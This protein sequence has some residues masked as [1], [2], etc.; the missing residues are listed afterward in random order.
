M[1]GEMNDLAGT[2]KTLLHEKDL[3]VA[4]L[5]ASARKVTDALRELV[6]IPIH[7]GRTAALGS[8][9]TKQR[10]TATTKSGI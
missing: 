6:T 3:K 8:T 5:C 10:A 1:A 7:W 9:A 2:A 4:E